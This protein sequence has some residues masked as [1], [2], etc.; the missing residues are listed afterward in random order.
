M[1]A[2][3]CLKVKAEGKTAHPSCTFWVD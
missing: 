2:C 1:A 3:I